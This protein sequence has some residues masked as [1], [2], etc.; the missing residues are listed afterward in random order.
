MLTYIDI[1]IITYLFF[2][3]LNQHTDHARFTPEITGA[4]DHNDL[5]AQ[6]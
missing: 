4:N 1:L 3:N 5:T 6:A 2:V